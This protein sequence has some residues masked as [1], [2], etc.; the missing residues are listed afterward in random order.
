MTPSAAQLARTQDLQPL[1]DQ[2]VAAGA[3]GIVAR[4]QTSTDTVQ[5]VSGVAN[6]DTGAPMTPE[7]GATGYAGRLVVTAPEGRAPGCHRVDRSGT[8]GADLG[9]R[10]RRSQG[11]P[12][13]SLAGLFH[14]LT[15]EQGAVVK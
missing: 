14:D 4:V 12:K 5:L 1:L 3:P 15:R 7:E 6:R 10:A 13:L 2:V 9:K 11:S 8:Q